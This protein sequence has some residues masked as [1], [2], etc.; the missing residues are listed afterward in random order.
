MKMKITE[1][2]L[3][4]FIADKKLM[5][6][7]ETA[8]VGTMYAVFFAIIVLAAIIVVVQ[9]VPVIGYEVENAQVI[10]SSSQWNGTTNTAILSGSSLWGTAGGI[11]KVV[12]IIALISIALIALFG[13]IQIR[14]GG[15]GGGGGM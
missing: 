5:L 9:F 12:V 13:I 1:K 14:R 10:P 4:K 3:R 15:G 6:K 7:D 11:V 2:G 8:N